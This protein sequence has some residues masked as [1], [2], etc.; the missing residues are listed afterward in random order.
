ALSEQTPPVGICE[1]HASE[2][3]SAN[4]WDAVMRGEP[5][6]DEGVISRDQVEHAVIFAND[7]I[8]EHLDL[9]A[10]RL[11]QALIKVREDHGIGLEF[12]RLSHLQPLKGKVRDERLRARVREH[13]SHL[14]FERDRIAQLATDRDVEEFVVRN[15]APEKE[16][17]P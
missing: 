5:F 3:S 10:E 7:R 9:S 6:V 16:R 4:V 1:R 14:L 11:P 15:L 17:E 2:Q 12:V 8:E 13:A